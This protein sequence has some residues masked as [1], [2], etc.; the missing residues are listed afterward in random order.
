MNDETLRCDFCSQPIASADLIEG[1]AVVI[2]QKRYCPACM[3]AA[4]QKRTSNPAKAA[5]PTPVAPVPARPPP[6]PQAT[7]R[8]Q[9]GQ[10]G[11][12]FYSSEEDRR[13]HLG[14]YLR[15]GLEGNEKVLHF[16]RNP[17]PEKLLGDF[18]AAGIAAKSYVD[19]GQLEIVS[20]E[21]LLG[22]T[23][24]FS[25]AAVADRIL[26][27]ADKALEDGW[28][29]LRVAGE[30][31]WALSAQIDIGALVDYEH[32]LTAL[33]ARGKCT[34]LCQ[35]NV[36]RFDEKSLHAIRKSHPYVFVK[37]TAAMV[38]NELGPGR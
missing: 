12:G 22:T 11:C 24:I 5:A 6:T 26:Q 23:G 25:A 8:L 3:S 4:I 21:K 32:K 2:L 31:T 17:T 18:R 33:A 30:M 28:T 29:R 9:L 37:G 14:P 7:R 16:L 1:R 10:H 34:S 19:R 38:V 13:H 15:E 36:Y 35:Y 27:A 20:V